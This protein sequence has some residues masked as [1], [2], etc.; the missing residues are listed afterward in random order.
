MASTSTRKSAT[1]SSKSSS[2]DNEQNPRL[3]LAKA[4]NGM[5]QKMEGF[6]KA[7]EGLAAFTK[8]QLVEFDMQIEARKEE[9][10]RLS[11]D[12]EHSRKRG[13]T[14][15]EL[16]LQEYRYEGAKKILAERGE[17]PIASS[18]LEGMRNTLTRLTTER[19]KEIDEVVKREKQ[20]HDAA[21]SAATSMQ[22]L[23]HEAATAGLTAVKEQQIREIASLNTTIT[24]LK[25]E[26][27]QQRK[28]TEAVAN[29]GRAAPITLST[30]GK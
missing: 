5:T 2:S 22:T 15:T 12:Y 18:D 30:N 6:N 11:E 26:V 14:E 25:D 16:F 27:A 10:K 7:A 28:L 23:R 8:D 3:E 17:V 29:A 21:L 19:E 20:R 9:L 24:N 1:S 13:R 4:I